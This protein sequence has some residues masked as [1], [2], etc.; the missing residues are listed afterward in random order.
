MASF[1]YLNSSFKENDS[2]LPRNSEGNSR[3][4]EFQNKAAICKTSRKLWV[5]SRNLRPKDTFVGLVDVNRWVVYIAPAFG[6]DNDLL[7][8]RWNDNKKAAEQEVTIDGNVKKIMEDE[9]RI[10]CTSNEEVRDSKVRVAEVEKV[11]EE[12]RACYIVLMDKNQFD[13]R[14]HRALSYWVHRNEDKKFDL[15]SALGFSIQRDQTGFYIRYVSNLNDKQG[16]DD[17]ARLLTFTARKSPRNDRTVRDLPKDWALS[18]E[19]V[20]ERQLGLSIVR[21]NPGKFDRIKSTGENSLTSKISRFQCKDVHLDQQHPGTTG[22]G[23]RMV[24]GCTVS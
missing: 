22:T 7:K 11:Y 16:N 18:L 8:L 1:A 14:A 4:Q 10:S 17:V 23:N 5:A 15:H 19:Q 2:T 24:A 20:L 3:I 12:G 21:A 6:I 13:G 9:V